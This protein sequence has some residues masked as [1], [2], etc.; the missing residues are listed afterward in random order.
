MGNIAADDFVPN[1][2]GENKEHNNN[3]SP[4]FQKTDAVGK[5]SRYS[6]F[7]FSCFFYFI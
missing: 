7:S 2:N 6:T 3:I 1:E 4:V 5:I